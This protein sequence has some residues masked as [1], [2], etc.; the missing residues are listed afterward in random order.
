MVAAK[1][2]FNLNQDTNNFLAELEQVIH[3]RLHNGGN[4]SYIKSLKEK[5]LNRITQKLGEETIETIIE[6][7]NGEDRRFV[8]EAADLLFHYLIL[9]SYKGLS[10]KEVVSV[11]ESRHQVNPKELS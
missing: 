3:Q 2:N 4:D 5:G 1:N 11:L 10:L 7:I 8:E 6:A 9:L